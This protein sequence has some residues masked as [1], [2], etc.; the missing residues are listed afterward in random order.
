[1]AFSFG[2]L[3]SFS[4]IFHFFSF[5]F[6][7][8]S[9][10]RAKILTWHA[11]CIPHNMV[12]V[13]LGGDHGQGSMKMEFQIANVPEPNSP[14]NTVVFSIFEGKDTRSNLATTLQ[15]YREQIKDLHSSTWR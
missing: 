13:K 10:D 5:L 7:F 4:W 8:I 2:I 6:W 12:Y 15:G 1:M 3:F 11:G 9:F 14:Q